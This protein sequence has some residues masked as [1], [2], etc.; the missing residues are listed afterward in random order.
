MV[1]LQTQYN[2]FS[3]PDPTTTY[4][5][6]AIFLFLISIAVVAAIVNN[7][8]RGTVRSGKVSKGGFRRHA[9]R[10]G[11]YPS[12]VRLLERLIKS[13]SINAP[14]RLLDGGPYLNNA[15]RNELTELAAAQLSE[16]E[17]ENQKNMLFQIK[18]ILDAARQSANVIS[19]SRNLR[20]GQDVRLVLEG[21]GGAYDTTIL[22]N[23]ANMFG[24]EIPR[25]GEGAP[26]RPAK[27]IRAQLTFIRDNNRVYRFITRVRG[28][29]TMRGRG[30][31]FFEQVNDIKEVQKRKSPRKE[32]GKPAYFYPVEIVESGTGRKRTREAVVQRSRN[33]LGR[34]EDISAGGCRL[35]AQRPLKK[36]TLIK[37][38][39]QSE[40]RTPISVF[41]KV[42][43]VDSNGSYGGD[44]HIMFTKVSQKHLNEIMSF[45]YGFSE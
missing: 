12:H 45:V 6:L 41:G 43:S 17:R 42:R 24:V 11:L 9:K 27:G 18:S 36:G 31:L 3:Q 14:Y 32:F 28:S 4:I 44:M 37:V 22:S 13:Q 19:S 34:I 38:E 39:F 20:I 7:R 25:D 33:Y 5:G 23:L 29:H 10:A 35:R 26:I 30:V 15:I 1:L 16:A 21:G 40:Q 8:R 2:F